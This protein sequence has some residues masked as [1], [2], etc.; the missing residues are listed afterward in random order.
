MVER[1]AQR[2]H[3]DARDRA[4]ARLQSDNAIEG[5]RPDHRASVWLPSASGTSPAATAAAEPDEDPPGV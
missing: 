5:R 1:R 4:K 2:V 3:A